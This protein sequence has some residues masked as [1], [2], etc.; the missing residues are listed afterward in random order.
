M[1]DR[2]VLQWAA[3][4]LMAVVGIVFL[5]LPVDPTPKDLIATVLLTGSVTLGLNC[6][7]DRRDRVETAL[8]LAEE[9]RS[10]EE[11][12]L[13]LE[14]V[15]QFAGIAPLPSHVQPTDAAT[16]QAGLSEGA[17]VGARPSQAAGLPLPDNPP[18]QIPIRSAD[19]LRSTM[20]AIWRQSSGRLD[21]MLESVDAEEQRSTGAFLTEI[22]AEARKTVGTGVT[23]RVR[24][25]GRS[26]GVLPLYALSGGDASPA[27]HV[28]VRVIDYPE[29]TG[30]GSWVFAHQVSGAQEFDQVLFIGRNPVS[31]DP[32]GAVVDARNASDADLCGRFAQF[33]DEAWDTATTISPPS[34]VE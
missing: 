16:R 33:F 31:G 28:Q 26:P 32:W 27:K 29:N 10:R 20:Y 8:R 2:S 9:R 5:F 11:L 21:V 14:T 7:V 1:D 18:V 23:T 17:H 34:S 3:S 15:Q 19:L 22:L 6:L 30:L 12:H 4:G 24:I 13:V 25:I